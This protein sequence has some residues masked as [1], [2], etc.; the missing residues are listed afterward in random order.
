MK[1]LR[2]VLELKIEFVSK[3]ITK[4]STKSVLLFIE[5]YI[6]NLPAYLF[7]ELSHWM[8]VFLCWCLG[9]VDT[10]PKLIV[11][12][13]ARWK[14][15]DSEGDDICRTE[16]ETHHMGI[17]FTVNDRY[18]RMVINKISCIMPGITTILLFVFSPKFMWIYYITQI[19]T[20]W[21]SVKDIRDIRSVKSKLK[22]NNSI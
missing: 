9:F 15:N 2:S 7:H 20:L 22:S 8:F 16:I 12:R 13:W 18:K 3:L 5:W 11:I 21:L 6:C 19:N 14:I 10:F 17:T 1:N 4:F